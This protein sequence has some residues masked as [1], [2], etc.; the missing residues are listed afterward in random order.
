MTLSNDLIL[1]K[2][3]MNN[4]DPWVVLVKVTLNDLGATVFR[5]ARN[6]TDLYFDDGSN[7][8]ELYTAFPFELDVLNLSSKGEIPSLVLRVCNVTRLLQP[9]L[10]DLAGGIGSS[11][12]LM[13]VHFDATTAAQTGNIADYADLV[14]TYDVIGSSSNEKWLVF[15]L[16]APSP[17]R[18]PFPLNKYYALHC[19]WQFDTAATPSPE[20]DY[21]TYGDG[22]SK[23]VCKRTFE[24]CKAHDNAVRF[25]GFVGLQSGGVRIV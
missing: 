2:N 24:D 16:G 6:Q 14:H 12:K 7:G 25:G 1:A 19:R 8:L 9:Y 11:V 4:P 20:C 23:T 13:V 3:K 22:L 21:L 18:Q 15:T 17:L 10:E 5:L